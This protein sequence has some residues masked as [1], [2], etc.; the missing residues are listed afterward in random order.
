MFKLKIVNPPPGSKYWWATYNSALYHPLH[1]LDLN[2]TWECPHSADGQT[3]LII[4]VLKDNLYEFTHYI[5]GLGPIYNDKAYI[6]DCNTS[7]LS[8]GSGI[9]WKW[10]AIGAGV[11]GVVAL[12]MPRRK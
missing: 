10:I 9:P 11:V 7:K 2:E 8:E 4:T 12:L 3:D 5:G 6:Y 1:F